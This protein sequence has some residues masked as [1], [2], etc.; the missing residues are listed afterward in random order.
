MSLRSEL[1]ELEPSLRLGPRFWLPLRASNAS[2]MATESRSPSR[3]D[4]SHAAADGVVTW[5]SASAFWY[6]AFM[7]K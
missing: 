6:Q 2:S 7:Q 3:H 5:T 4:S 1:E